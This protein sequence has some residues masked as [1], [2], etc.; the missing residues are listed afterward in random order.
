MASQLKTLGVVLVVSLLIW[1]WAEAE[2]VS[3]LAVTARVEFV[4]GESDLYPR[5]EETPAPTARPTT[6]AVGV[7]LRVRGSALAL[8][9]AQRLLAQTVKLSPGM[10]GM[11]TEPGT[12]A[13]QLLEAI[14]NQPDFKR[15]G[16]RIVDIEPATASLKLDRLLT[17]SVPLRFS[18]PGVA[19]TGQVTISPEQ[20]KLRFPKALEPFAAPDLALAVAIDP[21]VL[22]RAEDGRAITLPARVVLPQALLGDPAVSV[23]SE[24]VRVQ[25]TLRSRT[26]RWTV[27][28]VP[29]QLMI[30]PAALESFA[31]SMTPG[32][33]GSVVVSGPTEVLT[34]WRQKLAAAAGDAPGQA[35]AVPPAFVPVSFADLERAAV[36][37]TVLVRPVE[38][39]TAPTRLAFSGGEGV[40]LQVQITPVRRPPAAAGPAAAGA[41]PAASPPNP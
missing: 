7:R 21:A 23:D 8:E 25:L 12:Q 35:A 36:T 28:N 19:T 11:P 2:S 41:A 3:T 5:A 14:E 18:Q 26:E 6:P 16:L 27:E 10:P 32:S 29:V 22:D 15:A 34:A 39:I 9:Q 37:G 20:V 1:L 33:L 24:L 4:V 30:D 31:I 13:V 38:F 40:L 17:R